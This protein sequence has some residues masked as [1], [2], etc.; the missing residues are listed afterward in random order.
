MIEALGDKTPSIAESTFV[1]QAA[2][3]IGD[4]EIG[5]DCAVFPGAVIRADFGPINIG[6]RVLVEDN[7]V[8]HCAPPGLDIGNDVTFGHGAVVN[9]RRIGSQV[10]I[11][12]NAAILHDAEIG[13]R[14]IIAAGA[15]V[16]Q[17]MKVPDGS[18]VTGVPGRIAGRASESQLKWVERD[19]ELFNW[20]LDLYRGQPL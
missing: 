2:C 5:E 20:M 4:V 13:D 19:P 1:S 15:V 18:L 6:A 10:L 9:S 12:M 11:G 14:C 8:I 7:V 17:R 16:G 3:I